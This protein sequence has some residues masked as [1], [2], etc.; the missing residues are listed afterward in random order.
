MGNTL[1]KLKHIE[2]AFFELLAHYPFFYVLLRSFD[3]MPD[4]NLKTITATDCV[5]YIKYNPFLIEKLNFNELKF[6]LLHEALH[7]VRLDSLR[8]GKRDGLFW[9]AAC[10]YVI[11]LICVN[12]NYGE[13]IDG[14]L[15]D[16][17]FEN[18]TAEQI[19]DILCK[20]YKND[21]KDENK[22]DAGSG[23]GN[24][25][26]D[27]ENKI[28]AGD[29]RENEKGNVENKEFEDKVCGIEY[30]DNVEK[31]DEKEIIGKIVSAYQSA[32]F[33]G[34]V[35]A[36]IEGYIE[37]LLRV[38]CNLKRTLLRYINE[39]ADRFTDELDWS[40]PNKKFLDY[41]IYIPS[42][43]KDEAIDNIAF[44]FD[45]SGSISDA[46]YSEFISILWNLKKYLNFNKVLL[47]QNDAEI[48]KVKRFGDFETEKDLENFVK[49]RKGYGGTD[50]R[51]CFN[52]LNKNK[53]GLA[54]VFTDLEFDIPP[55]P[56]FKVIWVCS[57]NV[58]Y[59]VPYGILIRYFEASG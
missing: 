35:P 19:Y 13:I 15:F 49:N 17:K 12:E 2:R 56:R 16:R 59:K 9:N 43:K 52:Y 11:N 20:H 24:Y 39:Y 36:Y 25:K 50:F 3:L 34:K 40:R 7:I 23:E 31:I 27:K 4:E 55:V 18:K 1:N 32:K 8:K 21:I 30:P 26:K 58:N 29:N 42:Y 22:S 41:D 10:D 46:E 28:G 47:I 54:I 14:A 37:K 53:I 45:V 44:V 48:K 57:E 51:E 33:C 6:A 38:K 5:K